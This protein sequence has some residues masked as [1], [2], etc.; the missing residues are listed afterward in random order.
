TID[1]ANPLE[2]TTSFLAADNDFA[3]FYFKNPHELGK[4]VKREIEKGRITDLFLVLRLPQAPFPGVS[5]FP[6]FIGLDGGLAVNDVPI[7]GLSYISEDGVTFEQL[8]NFN[9][10]FQLIVSETH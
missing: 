5:A 10:R 3:P 6:P 8:A 2:T 4:R 1:L 7:F 9:F